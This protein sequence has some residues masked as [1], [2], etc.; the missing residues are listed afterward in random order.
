MFSLVEGG[1]E[2]V[3]FQGCFEKKVWIGRDA[4]QREE[5]STALGQAVQLAAS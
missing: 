5:S 2:R 3:G 4:F 1:L